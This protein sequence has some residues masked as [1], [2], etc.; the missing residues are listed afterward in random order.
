MSTMLS[1]SGSTDS[2]GNLDHRIDFNV[3]EDLNDKVIALA[4]VAGMSKA[5][6]VRRLVSDAV[7]G[8]F[9]MLQRMAH[10]GSRGQCEEHPRNI[11]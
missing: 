6:W 9:S 4:S 10:G 8:K 2:G 5:E 3:S 11:P 1:R 7:Y